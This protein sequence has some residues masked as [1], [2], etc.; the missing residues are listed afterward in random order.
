ME[1]TLDSR[2]QW[3]EQHVINLQNQIIQIKD[4]KHQVCDYIPKSEIIEFAEWYSTIRDLKHGLDT[5]NLYN[6]FLQTQ[7]Y[8]KRTQNK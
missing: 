8:S 3:L 2:V 6:L 5:N 1:A 7:N 4:M